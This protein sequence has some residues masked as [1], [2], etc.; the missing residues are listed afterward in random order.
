MYWVCLCL[1]R[2]TPAKP[3]LDDVVTAIKVPL[4]DFLFLWL[5][6]VLY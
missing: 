6:A 4:N 2:D 1:V 3:H 5:I